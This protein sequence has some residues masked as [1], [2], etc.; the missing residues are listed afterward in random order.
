MIISDDHR[1]QDIERS[2]FR[3]E[4]SERTSSHKNARVDP[5][6]NITSADS[7]TDNTMPRMQNIIIVNEIA[8]V[9]IISRINVRNF[10][11]YIKH[12]INKYIGGL[13]S[14]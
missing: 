1:G 11:N 9:R 13:Q 12:I 6:V 4:I 10:N 3:R 14:I 2:R 5:T 7:V 8:R